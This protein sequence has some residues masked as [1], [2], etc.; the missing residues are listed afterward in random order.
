M[1]RCGHHTVGCTNHGVHVEFTV[2]IHPTMVVHC[3]LV[4]APLQSTQACMSWCP[5]T[6]LT[7]SYRGITV[8]SHC[9]VPGNR[10]ERPCRLL[11]ALHLYKAHNT[12][13]R[14]QSALC[15]CHSVPAL[16]YSALSG[17]Q[18][19]YVTVSVLTLQ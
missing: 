6:H 15:L 12:T 8:P 13:P 4:S 5:C 11:C 17:H 3:V 16:S 10:T 18:C 2:A 7:V 19:P 14:H 9:H 1:R